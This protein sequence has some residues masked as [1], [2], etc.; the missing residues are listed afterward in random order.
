MKIE[1]SIDELRTIHL[2]ML[3]AKSNLMDNLSDP[4]L[5]DAAIKNLNSINPLMYQITSYIKEF[6]GA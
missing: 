5:H 2:C 4:I 6:K 3:G 1:L